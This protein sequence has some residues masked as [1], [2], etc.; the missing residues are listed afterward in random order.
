MQKDYQNLFTTD[1]ICHGVPSPLVFK[2]YL[3]FVKGKRE[4]SHINMKSKSAEKGTA[5]RIDF[6]DGKSIRRT[7]KTDLWNKLYFSHYIV[8][9]S[10]HDCQFTHYNRAGDITIGDYWGISKYYPKFYSEKMVSLVMVNNDKG[11]L[12]FNEIFQSID[13]IQINKYEASQNSLKAPCKPNSNRCQ[14]WI[15]YSEH[16]FKFI[17]NKYLDYNFYNRLKEHIRMILLRR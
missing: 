11:N 4:I 5:I 16:N 12:L 9:P 15:D 13:A 6:A 17:A 1:I 8:R 10:C 3:T 7:L 2:D 14:F